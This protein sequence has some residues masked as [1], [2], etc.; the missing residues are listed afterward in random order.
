[1]RQPAAAMQALVGLLRASTRDAMQL[2]ILQLHQALAV[3]I[4]QGPSSSLGAPAPSPFLMSPSALSSLLTPSASGFRVDFGAALASI[5]DGADLGAA[6]EAVPSARPAPLGSM[7]MS[8]LPSPLNSMGLKSSGKRKRGGAA[9]GG[10]PADFEA[11]AAM[12]LAKVSSGATGGTSGTSGTSLMPPPPASNSRRAEGAGGSKKGLTKPPGLGGLSVEVVHE[13]PI[14]DGGQMSISKSASANSSRVWARRAPGARC[15]E[16]A[17][18]G[19]RTA[20][21]LHT[22]HLHRACSWR[23]GVR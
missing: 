20:R 15:E 9:P 4:A 23:G 10:A 1:M 11:A 16:R 13:G 7:D 17:C 12:E 3:H 18:R 6:I 8:A 21:R 5:D 19:A 22:L 14:F 2:S